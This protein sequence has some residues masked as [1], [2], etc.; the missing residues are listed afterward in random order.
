MINQYNL[1]SECSAWRNTI[2]ARGVRLDCGLPNP[3]QNLPWPTGTTAEIRAAIADLAY[4]AGS[5]AA[6]DGDPQFTGFGIFITLSLRDC[7]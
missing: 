2:I 6:C 4:K 1:T 3:P 7:G 5:G